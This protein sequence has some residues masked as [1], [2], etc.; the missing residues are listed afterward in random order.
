MACSALAHR[1]VHFCVIIS[2]QMYQNLLLGHVSLKFYNSN[3]TNILLSNIVK[4]I[5]FR[6]LRY[7]YHRK[8]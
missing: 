1:T 7:L 3:A 8:N 4:G 2:L 5:R 6:I